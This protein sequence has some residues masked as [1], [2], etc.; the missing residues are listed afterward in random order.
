[1]NIGLLLFIP[2]RDVENRVLAAVNAAGFDVTQ[3]QQRVLMRIGPEGTRLTALAEAAQ[4]TKQTAGFLV[5]QLEKAGYVERVPDPADGRA[6]LVRVTAKALDAVPVANAELARIEAEWERH[7][8]KRR[9]AR[10]REALEMLGEITDPY[11]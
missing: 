9:M 8:G 10:L 4:V 3:A 6:R 5:D 2:N 11:R 7:L 1:M